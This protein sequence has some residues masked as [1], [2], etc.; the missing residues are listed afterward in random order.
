MPQYFR[1]IFIGTNLWQYLGSNSIVIIAAISGINQELYEAADIDGVGR[2]GRII[3]ITL[4]SISSTLLILLV[5]R[6]GFLFSVN[7][8]KIILLYSPSTSVSDVIA[9]FSTEGIVAV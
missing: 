7:F 3:H 6:L 1:S 2:F 9:T 4:P 8:E 5:L